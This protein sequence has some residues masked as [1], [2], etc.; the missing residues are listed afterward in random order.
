[1]CCVLNTLVL[2]SG[3]LEII[4]F[5]SVKCGLLIVFGVAA[6]DRGVA[7]FEY[8]LVEILNRVVLRGQRRHDP[9]LSRYF[10]KCQSCSGRKGHFCDLKC[11]DR[12]QSFEK[13]CGICLI[14][15]PVD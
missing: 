14:V 6:K 3:V 15:K 1:M 4:V 7:T 10:T 13:I 8:L 9:E 11:P 5:K 12:Q 2:D